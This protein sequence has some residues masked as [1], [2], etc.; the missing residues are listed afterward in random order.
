MSSDLRNLL[1]RMMNE[2]LKSASDLKLL[3]DAGVRLT[4]DGD[5]STIQDMVKRE[6]D[7]ADQLKRTID[8]MA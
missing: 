3:A 2:R 1:T 4:L 8:K 5:K 6:Y 7:S